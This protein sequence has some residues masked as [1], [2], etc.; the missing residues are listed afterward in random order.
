[1]D[2]IRVAGVGKCPERGAVGAALRELVPPGQEAA[3]RDGVDVR[4]RDDGDR[5]R[6]RVVAPGKRAEKAYTDAARDCHKRA[7]VAAVF[8]FLTIFPPELWGEALEGAALGDGGPGD[9]A[10]GDRGAADPEGRAWADGGGL[11]DRAGESSGEPPAPSSDADGSGASP[12]GPDGERR[13]RGLRFEL[14]GNAEVAPALGRGP[15]V[16]SGSVE[17]RGVLGRGPL[18][19]LIGVGYAP[20]IEIAVPGARARSWRVPASV[21][22]R[23]RVPLE[24]LWVGFDGAA[25]AQLQ[26][27]SGTS[28]FEQ[29]REVVL[30][31]GAR[32]GLSV[33]GTSAPWSPF[34]S[35]HATFL[36]DRRELVV[37]PRG[38]VGELP[39]V[40]LGMTLG[41]AL[42]L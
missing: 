5:Y 6:V 31:W 20:E 13:T 24:H 39:R 30:R 8:V 9:G 15:A 10:A 33:G 27:V 36:G 34:A 12:N 23:W 42:E 32:V 19:P 41:V 38:V 18:V 14:G 3:L 29:E 16:T 40:W 2:G 4:L 17:L 7:R 35:A 26:G 25:H 11:E 28:P 37:L 22:V 1:M 21:G